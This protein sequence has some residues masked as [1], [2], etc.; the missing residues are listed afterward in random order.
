MYTQSSESLSTNGIARAAAVL[1]LTCIVH[2][3]WDRPSTSAGGI[4]RTL[5][6]EAPPNEGLPERCGVEA[7]TGGIARTPWPHL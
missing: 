3:R 7:L 2:D 6:I 5:C 4:A 1:K